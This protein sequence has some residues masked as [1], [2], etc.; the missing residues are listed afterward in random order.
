M[1]YN[2]CQIESVSIKKIQLNF[3]KPIQFHLPSTWIEIGSS[4]VAKFNNTTKIKCAK[5]DL[6]QTV[7]LTAG[8]LK[9]M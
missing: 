5:Y 6:N 3:M 1:K 4:S 7:R 9:R 2:G 8:Q